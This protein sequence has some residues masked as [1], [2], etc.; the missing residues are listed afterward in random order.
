MAF[1]TLKEVLHVG[2]MN[3]Q[4]DPRCP[5]SSGGLKLKQYSSSADFRSWALDKK[6]QSHFVADLVACRVVSICEYLENNINRSLLSV[7]R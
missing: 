7:W 6:E 4:E 5:L 1:S 2:F 3:D